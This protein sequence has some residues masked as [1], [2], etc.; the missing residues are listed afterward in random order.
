MPKPKELRRVIKILA[1]YGIEFKYSKKG[2]H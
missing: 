2:K 1:K